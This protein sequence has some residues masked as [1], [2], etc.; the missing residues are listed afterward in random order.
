VLIK[1]NDRRVHIGG[2]LRCCTYTLRENAALVEVGDSLSCTYCH[3]LMTVG[4]DGAWFWAG[5][6]PL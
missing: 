2:L 6:T 5:Y 1:A 4:T 3:G